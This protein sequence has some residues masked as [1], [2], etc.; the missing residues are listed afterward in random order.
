[1]WKNFGF[2]LLTYWNSFLSYGSPI[3][4]IS[5]IVSVVWE[6][7]IHHSDIE[8]FNHLQSYDATTH[9][10]STVKNVI[11]MYSKITGEV[12]SSAII[13]LTKLHISLY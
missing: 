12:N 4:Q 1:M 13:W 7:I 9:F 10:E 5:V 8:V 3:E 11:A 2:P 6:F